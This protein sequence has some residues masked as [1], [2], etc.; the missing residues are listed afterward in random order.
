[1]ADRYLGPERRHH[2]VFV[3]RNTEYHFRDDRCVAVRDLRSKKWLVSHL[4]VDRRLTGGVRMVASGCAIPTSA[5]PKIGESLYFADDGRE[6]VTSALTSI[7]RP[8]PSCVQ[9]YPG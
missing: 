7:G 6:L 5:P 2:R 9:A 4:A 1:M 8:D 3:T